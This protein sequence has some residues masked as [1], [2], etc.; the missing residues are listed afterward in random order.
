MILFVVV[1]ECFNYYCKNCGLGHLIGIATD[2][3]EAESLAV[4]ARQV[5]P[6]NVWADVAIRGPYDA[7]V[8]LE[9]PA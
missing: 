7:N 3:A 9:V 8:M 5:G 2:E 6:S 4:S 1:G